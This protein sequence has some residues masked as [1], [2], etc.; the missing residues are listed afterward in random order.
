[1]PA[2]EERRFCRGVCTPPADPP[3]LI[4]SFQ[5]RVK[6]A[7]VN[8]PEQH[9]KGRVYARLSLCKGELFSYVLFLILIFLSKIIF[10]SFSL[11]GLLW[12]FSRKKRKFLHHIFLQ[13]LTKSFH[14][15][16]ILCSWWFYQQ[17][18]KLIGWLVFVP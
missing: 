7:R 18:F 17:S 14:K 8:A 1:M 6:L 12:F 2:N 11:E 10:F 16:K 4:S 15:K 13:K 9:A 3:P 5:V